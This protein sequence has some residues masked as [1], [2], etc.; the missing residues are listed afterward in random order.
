[1]E[2]T[3]K[4][5]FHLDYQPSSTKHYCSLANRNESTKTYLSLLI[6]EATF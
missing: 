4:L 1:M 2:K 5:V 3:C 6:I